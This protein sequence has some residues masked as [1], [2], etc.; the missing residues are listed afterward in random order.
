[1]PDE[2]ERIVKHIAGLMR[3]TVACDRDDLEQEGRIAVIHALTEY[4]GSRGASLDTF[5]YLK[6]RQA[7]LRAL[8]RDQRASLSDDV[9]LDLAITEEKD[10]AFCDIVDDLLSVVDEQERAVLLHKFGFYGKPE[11]VR[12]IATSLGTTES[13][14]KRLIQ[15]AVVK[16]I[17]ALRRPARNGGIDD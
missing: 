10:T 12:V 3:P 6:V 9:L 11:S 13:V 2:F 8:D 14:V 7:M 15:S 17:H 16:M 4:D 5:V 1:M